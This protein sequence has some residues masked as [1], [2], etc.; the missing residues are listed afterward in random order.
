LGWHKRRVG[1]VS[2]ANRNNL[3]IISTL[4]GLPNNVING[5]LQDDENNLW[6]STNKGLSRF[7]P[8]NQAIQKLQHSRRIAGK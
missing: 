4:D 3:F 5:I 2:T 6:I 1:S 8:G 7:N